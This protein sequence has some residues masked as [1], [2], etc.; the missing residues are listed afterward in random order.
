MKYDAI[1]ICGNLSSL[2]TQVNSK[3]KDGWKLQ[4][5]MS[6]AWD[7]SEKDMS[8]SQAMIKPDEKLEL[9]QSL[10][11]FVGFMKRNTDVKSEGDDL[12]RCVACSFNRDSEEKKPFAKKLISYE[13]ALAQMKKG[14][15]AERERYVKEDGTP[16]G[17]P[18]RWDSEKG[19]FYDEVGENQ[20]RFNPGP[21]DKSQC[22]AIV[23]PAPEAERPRPETFDFITALHHASKGRRIARNSFRVAE[24]VFLKDG[25][26]SI[27]YPWGVRGYRFGL[28]DDRATDWYIVG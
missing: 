25:V 16:I 11:E 12:C 8:F 14:A 13:E 22:W 2:T 19:L 5:G 27:N 23:T 24:Y 18:I 7:K 26:L 21:S 6:M 17:T 28:D 3:L 9:P 15:K 10:K 1:A 20:T 4:G